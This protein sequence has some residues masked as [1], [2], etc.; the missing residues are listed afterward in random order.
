MVHA[1]RLAIVILLGLLAPVCTAQASS[2]VSRLNWGT[3]LTPA[4]ATKPEVAS[5]LEVARN[6]MNIPVQ[7]V[8]TF[9]L[10]GTLNRD[11]AH[12][13][14]DRAKAD[15]N[16][17]FDLAVC[18]RTAQEPLRTQCLGKVSSEL[19]AWA[20]TY[21]ATGDPINDAYLVPL[22]QAIDLAA[23]QLSPDMSQSLIAWVRSVAVK[24]DDYYAAKPKVDTSRINNWN[25]ARLLI[26]AMAAMICNDPQLQAST[27]TMLDEF[28]QGNFLT[29]SEGKQDGETYDFV[30]RD[31]LDYQVADLFSLVQL[32]LYAP[33]LVDQQPHVLIHKGLDFIQP[34]F[35]GQKQHIE[36]LHT[37]SKFDIE[38]KTEDTNNPA[39][40]NKPWSP[41]AGRLLFRLARP[42]FPGTQS[43]TS[44][45]V[46]K[47]YDERIKLLAAIYGE[48]LSGT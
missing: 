6:S 2:E 45:V 31:A 36:F 27:R 35:L 28:V 11:P 18:A 34:Y 37:T 46:D 13:A 16:A 39:F 21:R 32:T 38:R 29:N 17:I 12:Q 41:A 9:H 3:L 48:P 42:A 33:S 43:W 24:G 7:P 8:D 14:S 19:T 4:A 26:R 5:V 47:N 1:N 40:Q 44:N 10:E 30:Q 25:A 15:F 20:K 22:F 23:P